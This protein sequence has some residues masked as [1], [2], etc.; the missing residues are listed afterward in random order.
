MIDSNLRMYYFVT[1]ECGY[2]HKVV[3]RTS[4][5][6]LSPACSTKLTLFYCNPE[7]GRSQQIFHH[8]LLFKGILA[9]ECHGFAS[10][11]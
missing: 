5:F 1:N 9:I 11:H 10:Q 8:F 4:G 7:G 3:C 6:R 2:G